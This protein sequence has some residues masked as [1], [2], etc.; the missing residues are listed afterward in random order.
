MYYGVLVAT[1]RYHGLDPLTYFSDDKLKIGQIV[2]V[3]LQGKPV[4][5]IIYSFDDKP[6]FKTSV[7][8]AM[9][10]IS[11]PSTSLELLDWIR[12]YYPSSIGV[13]AELF[14]P[15]SLPKSIK[16]VVI[17]KIKSH[18]SSLPVLTSGQTDIINTI[19]ER[20][21]GS[22]LLHGDTG[23]GK[24]RVYIELIKA[25]LEQGNSSLILTPEIGLTKP[26]LDQ[27]QRQFGD[28]VIVTH[29]QMTPAHR[30]QTWL[31]CL[32]T[33]NPLVIIGPRSAL[34][35][36]L[37]N[38]GVIV[39]D[40]AHDSSY[41]QEQAPHYQSTRVAAK[42]AK[43]HNSVLVLGSATPSI[44]DYFAFQ[45][46][47]LPILRMNQLAISHSFADE[48]TIVDQ[49]DKSLFSRSQLLSNA[50]IESIELAISK[51]EQS[52]IFLN[53]RGSARVLLCANCGWQAMC[54]HCSVALT[55]HQD[56][57]LTRCHSCEYTSIPPSMCP[58]C[59]SH[60]LIY[61]SPGTK[62]VEH[63]LNRLFSGSRIS[64]F[65]RDTDA[66]FRLQDLHAQ[67]VNGSVDI[68]IGTQI[69]VK[70]LDLPNLSVVGII[71]ADSGLQIPDYSATE[72]SYQLLSQV[73]GRVG[74]GHRASKLI[75]QSYNPDNPLLLL[76]LGKDYTKFMEQELSQRKQFNFPPYY[77]LL[78][79]SCTRSSS[80][81]AEQACAKLINSLRPIFSRLIIEG[82]TP[83]FVEKRQGKYSWQIIIKSKNRQSL[84]SVINNLPRSGIKYDLDPS[85]LL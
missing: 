65:D 7:I 27:F 24:T 42:L 69:V 39:V 22:Y 76:A 82:P 56:Q 64:R 30:R 34:F 15:P 2:R 66:T 26:L 45:S 35:M 21:P 16:D 67:L 25:A 73:A 53:R 44:S 18:G 77:H 9:W 54:P 1:Q 11:L 5:G 37:S 46:K 43:I 19:T 74:R 68:I 29:S 49:R 40:E 47:G 62:A 71:N 48:F 32:N 83:K 38:I 78:K 61:T 84:V 8:E 63:E 36:P 3:T 14:T 50:L 4:L 57:H 70:G 58:E 79:I 28:Q 13:I 17:P 80:K 55:F 72:R 33:T 85:D 12:I 23:S 52:M 51:G 59:S 6:S 81:S 10:D 41:K 31:R 60:D 75:V 20:G